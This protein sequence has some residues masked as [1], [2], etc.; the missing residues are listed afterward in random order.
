MRH[1]AGS[2]ML[3]GIIDVM[4]GVIEKQIGPEGMQ[5][6]A[7]VAPTKKQRFIEPDA[8]LP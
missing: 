1:M 3:P 8:P 2:D 7:F 4:A 5:E 6:G